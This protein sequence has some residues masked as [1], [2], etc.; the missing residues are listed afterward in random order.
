[1]DDTDGP[2][3]LGEGRLSPP[4]LLDGK[5]IGERLSWYPP[6]SRPYS[7]R[8]LLLDRVVNFG[9]VALGCVGSV[10]LLCRSLPNDQA[11]KLFG[12]SVYSVGIITML[13]CSAACHHYAWRWERSRHFSSVDYMGISA[14]IA[15][16]YTPPMLEGK[17]YG[18]LG[19]VWLLAIAG[20]ILDVFKV[21][22]GHLHVSGTYRC[23]LV[24]RFLVMGWAGVLVASTLLTCLPITWFYLTLA[25]GVLYTLGVPVFLSDFEFH[26]PLWHMFVITAAVCMYTANFTYIAGA[27]GLT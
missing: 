19:F 16:S 13:T 3:A 22:C 27:S 17:C 10:A 12:L 5:P 24:T 14:M 25:G 2:V 20:T 23:V 9:G 26:M 8:E 7:R 1:M 18:V 15:G 6:P 4:A 21:S 11:L